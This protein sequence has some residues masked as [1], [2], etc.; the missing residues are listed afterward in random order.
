MLREHEPHRYVK[1]QQYQEKMENISLGQI[2]AHV[3]IQLLLEFKQN[4][5]GSD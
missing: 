1:Q 3:T 5:E 2:K 4:R